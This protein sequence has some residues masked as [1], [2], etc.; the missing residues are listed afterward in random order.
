MAM[1]IEIDRADLTEIGILLSGVKN[2]AVKVL[3]RALNKTL[4]NVQT[5]AARRVAD[6]LNLSQKRIKEDFSQIK[7]TWSKPSATFISKGKPVGLISFSGTRATKAGV[8][9]KVKKSGARKIIDHAFIAVANRAEN[10]WRRPYTG[11]RKKVRPGFAYGA[12]PKKYR[13]PVPP[14]GGK[15]RISRLT[16]PRVEDELSKPHIIKRVMDHADERIEINL[17]AE[18]NYELSKL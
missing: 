12:L 5:E 11:E 1:N 13:F 10:V 15:G 7:A 16:G 9:V 18:L 6:D 17:D 8:S 14:G 3:T 4:A 2:G